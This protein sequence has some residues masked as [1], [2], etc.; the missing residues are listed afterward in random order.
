KKHHVCGVCARGFTTKGHLARH[1]PV[2]TRE[3]SHKCPFPGCD[4]KCSR[5]DNLK[6]Q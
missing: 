4:T 5:H 3:R 1:A 2:H 6:Q